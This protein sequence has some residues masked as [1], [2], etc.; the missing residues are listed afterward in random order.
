MGCDTLIKLGSIES[1]L[2]PR[3]PLS[4][5]AA[6]HSMPTNGRTPRRSTGSRSTY[7]ALRSAGMRTNKLSS[8]TQRTPTGPIPNALHTRPGFPLGL[9]RSECPS[10]ITSYLTLPSGPSPRSDLMTAVKPPD[11]E[12]TT[13]RVCMS[14]SLAHADTDATDITVSIQP[15]HRAPLGMNPI[16]MDLQTESFG[17]TR[18]RIRAP[19]TPRSRTRAGSR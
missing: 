3:P 1:Y 15:A 10:T 14:D 18:P 8:L 13:P 19:P 4:L 11:G 16:L 7:C 17:I 9:V 6:T 5:A 2:T 12:S